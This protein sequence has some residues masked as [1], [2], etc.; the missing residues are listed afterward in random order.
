MLTTNI[1]TLQALGEP[2]NVELRQS[3]KAKN[4]SIHIKL[5]KVELVLPY[6]ASQRSGHQ[7]LMSK[8]AW[9]REKLKNRVEV[10]VGRKIHDEYPML[11]EIYNVK[12]IYTKSK[13]FVSIEGS[14]I[15]VRAPEVK[16]F[17]ALTMFFKN[18][19]L[20]ELA[21]LARALANE[22]KFQYNKLSVREPKTRWGSCSST[23]SLVFNWRIIFAP[24]AV[25]RYLVTHELCHLKEMNHSARFWQLVESISPDY[26]K[27][28]AWL[29]EH[30]A[31]LHC[32]LPNDTG[33]NENHNMEC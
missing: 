12:H 14:E 10:P 27:S 1:V 29:K 8:E 33:K 15:V 20:W 6:R 24:Q 21:R 31:M 19:A 9:I 30:G 26:K 18:Q 2:I 32:Y 16:L 11:G 23:G 4:I 28:K 25:F 7:F 22:H 17:E 3:P 13:F 5:D